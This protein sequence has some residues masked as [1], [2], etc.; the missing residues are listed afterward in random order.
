[1]NKP[2]A[3]QFYAKD[4]LSSATVRTMSMRHRGVYITALA[5]MWDS[6]EPGTLPLPIEIAARSMGSDPRSLRDFVAKWPRCLV[7][8]EG[9]L[10]NPK[11]R[12]QWQ[13][14]QQRK[15]VLSDA[16]KRTNEKRWPRP[17]PSESP[18]DRSASASAFA[19]ARRVHTHA[20][21]N[22]SAHAPSPLAQKFFDAYPR[23]I[24]RRE[25]IREFSK[26]SDA[27][28]IRAVESLASYKACDDWQEDGG[29]FIPAPDKFL[30]DQRY[31]HPPAT[32][33][34]KGKDAK[35]KSGLVDPF[36]LAAACGLRKPGAA[37]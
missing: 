20:V 33:R 16:A 11:L 5:A 26:L 7:E 35:T 12:A 28:Q 17:S 22:R 37:N 15:Q 2:P 10:V 24:H 8:I 3:F 19:S 29:R 4:W 9:K 25:T 23:R 21:E 34:E 31:K 27:E 32:S 1:M 30:R 18:S 6:E 13:E 36:E 14:L